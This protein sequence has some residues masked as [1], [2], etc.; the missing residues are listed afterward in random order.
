MARTVFYQ[1][2]NKKGDYDPEIKLR[3][4]EPDA[5]DEFIAF[6]DKVLG[7]KKSVQDFMRD[8]FGCRGFKVT[9]Q[10]DHSSDDEE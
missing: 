2:A 10:Y 8:G 9:G 6:Q 1:I 5:W 7:V 3:G 4:N